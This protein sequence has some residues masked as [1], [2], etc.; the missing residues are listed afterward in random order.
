MVHSLLIADSVQGHVCNCEDF[1]ALSCHRPQYLGQLL[2]GHILSDLRRLP[3]TKKELLYRV[4]KNWN[5]LSYGL[6]EAIAAHLQARKLNKRLDEYEQILA[7]S[8]ATTLGECEWKQA[9]M[10]KS[11]CLKVTY[12]ENPNKFKLS[13]IL[14][15]QEFLEKRC[16]INRSLFVDAEKDSV[17]LFL[18]PREAADRLRS[19]VDYSILRSLDV[20]CL[21]FEGVWRR[22]IHTPVITS[23]LLY[24]L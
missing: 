6:L 14:E 15:F 9:K 24:I 7:Q 22:T 19:E 21:E 17:I 5:A 23:T 3:E 4:L 18:I 12:L 10:F 1:L 8:V 2:S 16:G 13:R 11:Q 20:C